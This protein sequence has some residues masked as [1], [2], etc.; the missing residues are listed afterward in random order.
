MIS[1]ADLLQP[2]SRKT[3]EA[4]LMSV[5]QTEPI[6]GMPGVSFPVTDWNVGSFERTHMKM[7]ATGFVDREDTIRMLTASGFLDL[8]ASLVDA[9][10]QPVEGWAEL[11]AAQLYRLARNDATFSRQLLTL[12]CTAGP[13]PYTRAAGEI[14]AMS[15]ST[16]NTY[17]NIHSVTIPDDGSVTAIFQAE[18]PGV[19]YQDSAGS[20][21]VLVTP[22]GGVSVTNAPTPAGVPASYLTG[23][24]T[25]AVTSTGIS[26]DV[27]TVK[28]A[29][30]RGGRLDDSTALITV[31]VYRGGAVTQSSPITAT[32][33]VT[34][35]DLQLALADGFAGTR[36]FNSGDEWIVCVPGTPLLQAG[37][38]KEPLA[39]LAQRCRD[40]WPELGA[41]PTANR[42]AGWVRAC[43]SS[44]HLGVTKVKTRPSQTVAGVEEVYIAGPTGTATPTQVAAVQ[45]YIDTRTGTIDAGE[46]IAASARAIV[47]GGV[48]K[49]RHG[50]TAAAKAA[51]DAAWTAYLATVDIGGEDPEGLVKLLALE[52]ILHDAG[53]YNVAGLTLN[54]TAGDVVL[55]AY[56]CAALAAN[57]YGLPSLALTWLEVS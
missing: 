42:Y 13:G 23:T 49:C 1:L 28:I 16:G 20:I 2:R 27:R 8:A 15:P 3:I 52:D 33:V 56:E 9:T 17:R 30:T 50:A 24:G 55:Q 37:A 41:I 45:A 22:M 18:S 57:P 31:T 4:L 7:I 39:T 11:L 29:F 34:S 43:E 38:D 53:V 10:G 12:T 21:I 40:R 6:D 35:D 48:A 47:L 26:S 5:L 44:Q 54:G 51:A 32:A 19:G 36:S 14:I 25:I 46:V